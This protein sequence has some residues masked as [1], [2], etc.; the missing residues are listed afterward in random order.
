[1]NVSQVIELAREWVE[2]HGSRTQG[3]CGAH[4]MGSIIRMPKNAPFPVHSD[5]DL[6]IVLRDGPDSET[7]NLS[8]KGLLLEHT[9]V[10]AER[11]R[12]AEG[13]LADP[14]LASDLVV[15]SILTDPVEMLAALHKTVAVEYPRRKWVIARCDAAKNAVRRSLQELGRASSPAEAWGHLAWLVVRSLAGLIGIADL[16][17]PTNRRCL[18]LAREVLGAWGRGGLQEQM[19]GVL[20]CAHLSRPQVEAYL[21]D[22]ATAFDRAIEVT[23]TPIPAGFR[24]SPHVKPSFV[25]G[26]REMI[27][28]GDHRE[29]VLWIGAHLLLS[30]SAIQMDAPEDE[31]PQFQMIVDE[32]VSDLG[33]RTSEDISSRYQRAKELTDSIFEVADDI[34]RRNPDIVE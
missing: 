9:A 3:F 18:V 1:M 11:Y 6:A 2:N 4:L 29:A 20:G 13:L 34:V 22:C 26:L 27:E 25:G 32:F 23:R 31:K 10:D 21:Q 17:P 30:N 14:W 16:R 5:V 19:L 7:Q 33:L 8:Y 15:D 12:S 28:E 24:L